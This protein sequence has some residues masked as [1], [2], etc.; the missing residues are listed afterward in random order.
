MA[1]ATIRWG[2]AAIDDETKPLK[3]IQPADHLN[4][5]GRIGTFIGMAPDDLKKIG[6]IDFVDLNLT[7]KDYWKLGLTKIIDK[8][9]TPAPSAAASRRSAARG[10]RT[11]AGRSWAPILLRP[12]RGARARS[13]SSPASA[14]RPPPREGD[15]T[16]LVAVVPDGTMAVTQNLKRGGWRGE[17]GRN[18]ARAHTRAYTHK[19][20]RPPR[21]RRRRASSP[22]RRQKPAPRRA[23]RRSRGGR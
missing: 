19:A 11:G 8:A 5:K 10:A 9:V 14:A 4:D 1:A 18:A 13:P 15:T 21:G 2:F 22:R 12:S 17:G 3:H 7:D 23:R 6:G 20:E 16:A